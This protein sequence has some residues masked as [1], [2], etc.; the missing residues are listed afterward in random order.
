MRHQSAHPQR[1]TSAQHFNRRSQLIKERAMPMHPRINFHM[2][3]EP[4]PEPSSL[5]RNARHHPR[6]LKTIHHHRHTPQSRH[7][8]HLRRRYI[9]H[10]KQRFPHPRI[11]QHPRLH[12][13]IRHQSPHPIAAIQISS[14]LNQPVSVCIRLHHHP[15]L[16]PRKQPPERRN[17]PI[18]RRAT[19]LNP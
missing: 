7:R 2:H 8:C 17:I 1:R 9:P 16:M 19:Q 14:H 10:N 3:I 15:Q 5:S 6:L 4:P 12:D 18:N 13:T 11:T